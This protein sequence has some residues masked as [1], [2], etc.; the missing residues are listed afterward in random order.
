MQRT[1]TPF[2][3]VRTALSALL[4]WG[5]GCIGAPST[6]GEPVPL[7]DEEV[8]AAP[9][10]SFS[11]EDLLRGLVFGDGPVAE[12]LP[13]IQEN[14]SIETVIQDPE[15]LGIL[16]EF[17]NLT[18]DEITSSH[19]D[20]A[21]GFRS[22]VLSG[23]HLKIRQALEDAA[24]LASEIMVENP[25]F[26]AAMSAESGD[27]G[28]GLCVVFGPVFFVVA[29]A[30]AF[31]AA[32]AVL[33]VAAVVNIG[34]LLAVEAW[35]EVGNPW[36]GVGGGGD[37]L[38]GTCDVGV[39]SSALMADKLI[40]EIAEQKIEVWAYQGSKLEYRTGA[41]YADG[42]ADWVL[43][44]G[45]FDGDGR[46][47]RLYMRKSNPD[48]FYVHQ[49]NGRTA[50]TRLTA[51]SAR[52]DIGDFDGDSCDDVLT[53]DPSSNSLTIYYANPSGSANR[54]I[55]FS[56]SVLR[57][58]LAS[59]GN[60][61]PIVGRFLPPNQT[62]DILL[63]G[64]GSA[65]EVMYMANSGGGFTE[66]AGA[67]NI[68][69]GKNSVPVV[70]TFYQGAGVDDLIIYEPGLPTHH[71][72]SFNGFEPNSG[73]PESGGD[74]REDPGGG[75]KGDPE[76]SVTTKNVPTSKDLFY[77]VVADFDG[78]GWDDIYWYSRTS[79]SIGDAIYVSDGN[80]LKAYGGDGPQ[81]PWGQ[82]KNNLYPVAF[83][84]NNSGRP[85]IFWWGSGFDQAMP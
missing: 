26:K 31:N 33:N 18:V 2:I 17:I 16:R 66:V 56:P 74:L 39:S 60:Y 15:S 81:P 25:E 4:L 75:S 70:G 30:V 11:T 29:Y 78:N 41:V 9:L 3:A 79:T 59:L 27:N 47:D 42:R 58:G 38:E 67:P 36:F 7:Y 14:Y 84:V 57:V 8:E 52:F 82:A 23:D 19:A 10:S 55:T 48:S 43:S 13:T 1:G 45:D 34:V 24:L 68:T 5:Q 20:F 35:V 22:D 53:F 32:A 40:A 62:D 54:P 61:L 73:D 21:E 51:P 65:P 63:W 64:A 69:A 76:V 85:D 77:P 12:Q 49:F 71:L 50:T 46:E 83:D 80:A 44:H 37:C 28:Q 6:K 72:Y